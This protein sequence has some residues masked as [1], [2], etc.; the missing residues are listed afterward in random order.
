[1]FL[2]SSPLLTSAPTL[3]GATASAA[4]LP[5]K[6][7][8][9]AERW[10][11]PPPSSRNPAMGSLEALPF[12]PSMFADVK[13]TCSIIIYRI[14]CLF[15]VSFFPER[16]CGLESGQRSFCAIY[17]LYWILHLCVGQD[18]RPLQWK[19]GHLKNGFCR[20]K[21]TLL[22]LWASDENLLSQLSSF[23]ASFCKE[24]SAVVNEL[25]PESLQRLPAWS[26]LPVKEKRKTD[27]FDSASIAQH[28]QDSLHLNA[29]G[30]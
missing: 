8:V 5:E 16:G 23:S 15:I 26:S 4:V 3:S 24:A 20:A 27:S 6:P 12:A 22:W 13:T 21:L 14:I 7:G 2:T 17:D 30:C 11:P 1:M 25:S 28:F 18:V 19:E 9:Y 10:L 29:S